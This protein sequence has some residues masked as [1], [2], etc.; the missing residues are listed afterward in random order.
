MLWLSVLALPVGLLS[1]VPHC[2]FSYVSNMCVLTAGCGFLA[3]MFLPLEYEFLLSIFFVFWYLKIFRFFKIVFLFCTSQDDFMCTLTEGWGFGT[4]IIWPPVFESLP[5][6]FCFF[7]SEN[8]HIFWRQLLFAYLIFGI[9]AY[10]FGTLQDN[11]MRTL[12]E[13]CGFLTTLLLP[14]VFEPVLSDAT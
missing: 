11:V 2:L 8:F 9:L 7:L 6:D 4:T 3:T 10:F 5:S 1:L 13:G 12:T 14:F